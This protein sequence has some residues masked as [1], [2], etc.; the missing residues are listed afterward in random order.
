MRILVIEDSER[1]RRSL[2]IGLRKSGY[3]VDL[4]ADGAQGLW[5][6]QSNAY[7]VIILD[8]M[9]PEVD[10][11]TILQTLRRKEIDSQVLI[12]TAKDS[13][14]D[15][16]RGLRLG[17]D[18]YL[19][20]PFAFDELLARIEVL[21]RRRHGIK[22]PQIVIGDLELDTAARTVR[23]GT[24][25]IELPPREYALLEYLA[26]RKGQ[27][28]SRTEIE[29]HI[30]DE[31]VEPASNVIDA[32]VYALRRKIDPADGPSVICT[33]RGM[34]YTLLAEAS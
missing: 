14:E 27:V 5:S 7:D 1:L 19:V 16:V 22:S 8:L 24:E 20:K 11:L 26:L 31:H 2:A 28:V 3:A 18:D 32:A 13:V 30:Y 21:T 25:V 23:R 34:G 6:A 12:L 10:G 29:Q 9:L 33:R 4:A 15:R 17:A